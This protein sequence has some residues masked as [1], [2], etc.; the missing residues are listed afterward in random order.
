VWEVLAD[1]RRYPMWMPDVAWVSRVAG[2][3]E[4]VG[5]ELLV[6]TRVFGLPVANDLMV[7]SGWEPGRRMAIRHMGVVRGPAEWVL[8]E[9]SEG[10]RFVWWEDVTMPPGAVGELALRM[11]WPWQRRMFRRSIENIRRLVERSG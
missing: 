5:L 11:Y 6:R 10:T 4:G 8:S 7:V 9:V 2:P 1:W 3:D